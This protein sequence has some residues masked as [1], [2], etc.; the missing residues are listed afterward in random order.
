MDRAGPLDRGA[1]PGGRARPARGRPAR[2]RRPGHAPVPDR[3]RGPRLRADRAAL[4]AVPGDQPQLPG[5][6]GR[7]ACPA[8]AR[9]VGWIGAGSF[10]GQTLL[11]AFRAARLTSLVAVASASGLSARC[12]A[13]RHGFTAAVSGAGAVIDHPEVDV[14]VVATPHD[15]H[16]ELT[17][18]AL[19]AGRHVWCEKPLA[20]SADG[21]DSVE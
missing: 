14:V 11:P 1:E 21:V 19:A 12:F 20:L 18:R 6:A 7:P 9:G 4:R 2:R 17:A 8:G 5:A 10:S 13:E 16:A 3:G 15:S